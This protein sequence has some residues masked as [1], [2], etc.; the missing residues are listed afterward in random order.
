M[1]VFVCND[2]ITAYMNH[3]AYSKMKKVINKLGI[4]VENVISEPIGAFMLNMFN[5]TASGQH[6]LVEPKF[7][8]QEMPECT[9]VTHTLDLGAGMHVH[10]N[11]YN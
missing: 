6:Q 7:F 1:L 5:G 11:L 2:N 3:E 8:D 9:H 4:R 10:F